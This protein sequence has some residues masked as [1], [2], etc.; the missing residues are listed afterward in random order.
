MVDV[1]YPNALKKR[2]SCVTEKY[3][4]NLKL[5]CTT[6]GTVCVFSN[7]YFILLIYTL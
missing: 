5:R 3:C 6:K 7:I 2:I 4:V 1:A